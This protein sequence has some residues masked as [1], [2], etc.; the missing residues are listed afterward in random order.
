MLASVSIAQTFGP[1]PNPVPMS[2]DDT[3]VGAPSI[4]REAAS[5]LMHGLVHPHLAHRPDADRL[6]LEPRLAFVP[7][8][9]V[10]LVMADGHSVVLMVCARSDVPYVPALPTS[11][12]GTHALELLPTELLPMRNAMAIVHEGELVDPDVPRE[13]AEEI[14]VGAL[15]WMTRTHARVDTALFVLLP[16]WHVRHGDDCELLVDARGGRIVSARFPRPPTL[17]DRVRRFFSE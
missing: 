13:R 2:A 9:R 3:W 4:A 15:G 1:I 11:L 7:F 6:R 5:T 14:A 10:M 12:G 8:W 16:M 17:S